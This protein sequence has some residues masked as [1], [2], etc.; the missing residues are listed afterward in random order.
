MTENEQLW[1]TRFL[2]FSLVRL[3]GLALFLIGIAIAFTDLVQPGGWPLLGGLMA[4]AGAI[5]ALFAPRILR[6]AW[7]QQDTGK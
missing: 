5:D 4:I 2:V 1:R 6:K 7:E 3:A